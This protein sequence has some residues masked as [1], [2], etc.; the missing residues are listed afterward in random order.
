TRGEGELVIA[1]IDT[2]EDARISSPIVRSVFEHWLECR[3]E[4]PFPVPSDIN[5]R[6][7]ISALPYVFIDDLLDGGR[8]YRVRLAGT[9]Y[10]RFIGENPTG[11][12][13]TE[14]DAKSNRVARRTLE[15]IRE[16]IRLNSA[17]HAFTEI[18]VFP[19]RDYNSAEGIMMPLSTNGTW[20]D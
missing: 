1:P 7:I 2:A 8:A 14:S 3:G 20:I 13:F 10:T 5:P 6:A 16:V 19:D 12:T 15:C 9:G 17:I 11:R 4:R 18:T